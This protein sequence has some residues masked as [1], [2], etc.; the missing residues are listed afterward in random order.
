M[1]RR[2]W[3]DGVVGQEESGL[4]FYRIPVGGGRRKYRGRFPT[5]QLAE[6]ARRVALGLMSYNRAGVVPDARAVPR[7]GEIR[8]EF[9][10]RRE[11]THRAGSEDKCRWNVHMAATFDPLR[12]GEVSPAVIRQWVRERRAAGCAGSSVKVMIA[13]LSGLFEELMESGAVTS[14]P[15]HDLPKSVRDQLRSDHDSETVPFLERVEDVRRVYLALP[16]HVARAFALGALAGLRPSEALALDWQTVDLARGRI[17]VQRQVSGV[18]KNRRARVVPIQRA[19]APLLREWALETGGRGLVAPPRVRIREGVY[20]HRNTLGK[21]LRPVLALLGLARPGLD[22]YGATRHTF[23][24]HW[25][26]RGKS[27]AILSQILGH[28]SV[29]VTERYAHLRPDLYAENLDD[30]FGDSHWRFSA[31]SLST[32]VP[33]SG[34]GEGS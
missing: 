29:K 16:K 2:R 3:G 31:V 32:V 11:A 7:I 17:H 21:S 27:I 10:D 1:T 19:L 18:L 26:L 23:A 9:L 15:T 30:V 24:S 13:I 20:L 8:G 33:G 12:P 25:V 28:S 6:D 34:R 5:K 22:Y 4:W 14:N